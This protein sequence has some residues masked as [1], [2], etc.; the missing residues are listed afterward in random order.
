M[1]GNRPFLRSL[2]WIGAVRRG[3]TGRREKGL[4]RWQDKRRAV[5][6]GVGNCFYLSFTAS[7]ARTLLAGFVEIG[8]APPFPAPSPTFP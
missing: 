2:A 8:P 7:S 3:L 4:F 1:I 5:G 6:W